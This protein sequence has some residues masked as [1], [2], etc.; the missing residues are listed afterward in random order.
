MTVS[1][2]TAKSGPYTGNGVTT[3]FAYGFRILDPGHITVIRTVNGTDTVVNPVDYTVSGVGNL[4]G[5]NVTFLVA[6]TSAHKIS[7]IRNAPFTQQ[8]DLENQGAYYAE[9]VEQAF[10]LAAMRDQ[11]VAEELS[12]AMKIPV[13]EDPAVLDT[14]VVDVLRLADSANEIDTVAGI[15]AD[16]STVAAID[17]DVSTV[18]SVY[19]E[20]ETVAGISAN[21]TTVAGIAANVTTVAGIQADVQVI[22]DNLADVTNFADVYLG[23]KAVAPTLRNDGSALVAGDLY[24]D[25]VAQRLRGWTGTEWFGTA[26]LAWIKD[27]KFIA[28]AGQTVFTGVDANGQALALDD[29]ALVFLNGVRLLATVDYTVATGGGTLTLVSAAALNDELT[30]TSFH[31]IDFSQLPLI[32]QADADRAEAAAD[33]I[34]LGTFDADVAATAS[35]RV[36]AE[37]ARDVAR[38]AQ[39]GAS[40]ARTGAETARDAAFVNANVYSTIAAGLAA[41][42]DGVQFQVVTRDEIVRYVRTNSTTATEV[43]RYPSVKLVEPTTSRLNVQA[44]TVGSTIAVGALL[45]DGWINT[46]QLSIITTTTWGPGATNRYVVWANHPRQE[47]PFLQTVGESMD[48]EVTTWARR[49]R[50]FFRYQGGKAI[51]VDFNA[52]TDVMEVQGITNISESNAT[53]QVFEFFNF[54]TA[55][56]AIGYN[57]NAS[58]GDRWTFGISGA[59]IYVKFNGKLLKTF[60]NWGYFCP[61]PGKLGLSAVGTGPYGFR[62]T[63]ATLLED[64]AVSAKLRNRVIDVT[65]AGIKNLVTTGSMTAGSNLLTTRSDPGFAVGDTVIVEIGREAGRGMPGTKGVGGTWPSQSYANAAAMNAATPAANTI[66]W[67]EDTGVVYQYV[68]GVWVER[69]QSSTYTRKAIPLSLVSKIT[70]INEIISANIVA[71]GDF[72]GPDLTG[73]QAVS[74]GTFSIVSGA[75]EITPSGASSGAAYALSTVVG[76]TYKVSLGVTLGTATTVGLSIGTAAS[77][78]TPLVPSNLTVSVT[79]TKTLS[80]TATATTHFL[81]IFPSGGTAQVDNVNVGLLESGKVLTLENTAAVNAT[82]A[83]VYVEADPAVLLQLLGSV[84]VTTGGSPGLS[85]LPWLPERMTVL[86]PSGRYALSRPISVVGDRRRG[87]SLVGEA[88][89]ATTI[90][91]PKGVRSANIAVSASDFIVRNLTLEGNAK[92][93]GFGINHTSQTAYPS[94]TAYPGGIT[95]SGASNVLVTDVEVVDAWQSGIGFSSCTN[96]WG[97]NATVRLT[98][99]LFQYIQWMLQVSDSVGGGFVDCEVHSPI[100][101]AALESFRSTGTVFQRIKLFNGGAAINSSGNWLMEDLEFYLDRECVRFGW[102]IDN[103]LINVNTNIQPAHPDLALGGVIRRPRVVMHHPLD[104]FTY[105]PTVININSSN[106]NVTVE[107]TYDG[108]TLLHPDLIAAPDAPVSGGNQRGAVGVNSTATNTIVRNIRVRGKSPREVTGAGLANITVSGAGGQVLNCV[109]DLVLVSNG[110][111][112]TGTRTNAQYGSGP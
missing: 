84:A 57:K 76:R 18:A 65:D 4:A 29:V 100:M 112:A 63:N 26:A 92:Q 60:K 95:V 49:C 20:V 97:R 88:K 98:D 24:F 96:C 74:S 75:L 80:F 111:T 106:T 42:A 110:A 2:E 56:Q 87:W 45:A 94:G 47:F 54:L 33:R 90:F 41:V 101:T 14:L 109:A 78:G 79:G 99:G 81:R 68:G 25:T 93:V 51:S 1:S 11:Q 58:E 69:S 39:T 108:T 73:W 3:V 85:I 72:S 40:L 70:A 105:N 62:D 9:V 5:G 7:V 17:A 82:D 19:A 10:D 67:L 36:A 64:S 28:T 8:T 6:P 27:F 30:I 107:G 86:F 21:V 15:A 31:Q 103:P 59:D 53:S 50:V 102:S 46:H 77:G 35:A 71:N 104:E 66:A 32:V 55:A 44:R 34:D 91:S 52:E 23:P 38:S 83:T 22:A 37:A 13:G 61:E 12:R 89:G 43:A 48:Q 16:V